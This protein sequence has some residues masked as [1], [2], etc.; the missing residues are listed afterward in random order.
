MANITIQMENGKIYYIAFGSNTQIVCRYKEDD[1]MNHFFYTHLHYW[2]GFETYRV[3]GHCCKSDI[4]ELRA[5]SK[6]EKHN[7]FN[8]EVEYGDV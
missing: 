6:S 4:T 1:S 7:L 2:N 8:H 5:A 3:K